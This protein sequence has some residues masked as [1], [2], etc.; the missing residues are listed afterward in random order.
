MAI[1]GIGESKFK[2]TPFEQNKDQFQ[3]GGRIGGASDERANL[4]YKTG[5]TDAREAP[6]I[7]RSM[8]N[9]SRGVQMGSLSNLQGAATGQ[10]Q[11]MQMLQRSATGQDSAAALRGAAMSDRA[12][13]DQTAAAG[14]VRGGPGAQAAAFRFAS[15]NAQT[16]RA[17]M[18]Q[19]IAAEAAQEQNQARQAFAGAMGGARRDL[20]GAATGVRGQD[21]GASLASAQH[22]LQSRGLNDQ[23]AMGYEGFSQ[24]V[25][26][27]QN[28]MQMEQQRLAADSHNKA[29]ELNRQTKSEN[30]KAD[31]DVLGS[32]AGAAAGAAMFLSDPRVKNPMPMGSLSSM[33]SDVQ[34]KDVFDQSTT[35][36]LLHQGFVSGNAEKDVAARRKA[37]GYADLDKDPRDMSGP[38]SDL[39]AGITEHNYTAPEEKGVAGAPKGYAASRMGKPGSMFGY[40]PDVD[41]SVPGVTGKGKDQQAPGTKDWLKYGAGAATEG[42]PD[43]SRG[44]AT[45]AAEDPKKGGDKK[46]MFG[47]MMAGVKGSKGMS[48]ERAKNIY[49]DDKTKLAQA[50]HDGAK[51]ANK[52]SG[53][54]KPLVVSEDEAPDYVFEAERAKQK[55]KS[56]PS[57]SEKAAMAAGTKQQRQ[58][59]DDAFRGIEPQASAKPTPAV[60]AKPAAVAPGASMFERG[61]GWQAPPPRVPVMPSMP[62]VQTSLYS[63]DR[64][65]NV[66]GK[67]AAMAGAARSMEPSAYTYK[68]EFAA[69]AGQSP[70]E[71]NVGPMA[72]KMAKDPVAGTAIE[73][74]DETGMLT[75]DRDKGLKVVMGS[76]ASLQ[77]Q[78][79]AIE[80]KKKR[81]A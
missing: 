14:G 50:W 77:H 5:I 46:S 6:A 12:L 39:F 52:Q 59:S 10:T 78:I 34:S 71:L 11:D 60:P 56:E 17:G 63:D 72:N 73:R 61:A 1:L 35:T 42:E 70:E 67:D 36:P 7:D 55:P 53:S 25:Q 32:I 18:A 69:K 47:A 54:K 20:A 49:S 79:D 13:R 8:S 41:A 66:S 65:K 40:S 27:Q 62:P 26:K 74:D 4:N 58:Q 38:S 19:N 68:P 21:E 44:G 24:G 45:K 80:S 16:Q 64:S 51:F 33:Y 37:G 75:I 23:R 31:T 48:D 9:Q 30:A 57:A 3:Y 43:W 28:E 81:A 22:E 29:Q 2:A 76:L 15:Q